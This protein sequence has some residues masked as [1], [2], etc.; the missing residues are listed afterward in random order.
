MAFVVQ[1][2]DEAVGMASHL[3]PSL[4]EGGPQRERCGQEDDG[5]DL[6]DHGQFDGCAEAGLLPAEQPLPVAHDEAAERD[7]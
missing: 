4:R 2:L 5:A 3:G 6:R 7:R 1:G